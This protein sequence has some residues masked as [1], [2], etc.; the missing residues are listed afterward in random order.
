MYPCGQSKSVFPTHEMKQNGDA[1]QRT[2]T[3]VLINFAPY[4]YAI[5]ACGREKQQCVT[6]MAQ[7]ENVTLATKTGHN[8]GVTQ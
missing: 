4:S 3:V 6:A 1:N 7:M 5:V 2:F 8:S